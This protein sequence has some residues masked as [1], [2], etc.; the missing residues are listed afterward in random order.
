MKGI[1][2][3][4]TL[5]FLFLLA[6]CRLY[7]Q[8]LPIVQEKDK[9]Q[10][11][12]AV[13]AMYDQGQFV[14]ALQVYKEMLLQDPDNSNLN[15]LVADCLLNIDGYEKDAAP[16]LQKA[17]L[18]T[19]PDYVN[20]MAQRKAPVFAYLKLGDLQYNDYQFDEALINY[21]IF[22]VYLDEKRDKALLEEVNKKI[23]T[24]VN[25]RMMVE[26][27]VKVSFSEIPFVNT[28]TFSDYGAQY[29]DKG[30]TL[31]FSRKRTGT[32]APANSDIFYMRK[33]EGKWG[34]PVRMPFVNSDGDDNFCC[35]SKDGNTMYFAS[36]RDGKF[37]IYSATR[38]GKTQWSIPE[39]L[40][41]NINTAKSEETFAWISADMKTLYF[42]SDRKGGYGG[43]DL[44]RSTRTLGGDWGPAENL[45]SVVNTSGNEESP[46]LSE[47]GKH[48][49]FSS[50]GH[51]GMGG[52]DVFTAQVSGNALK[53]IRNA[54]F[55]INTLGDDLYYSRSPYRDA[56]FLVSR[57]KAGKN[58]FAITPLAEATVAMDVTE[59]KKKEQSKEKPK[60]K[61]VPKTLKY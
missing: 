20:T 8:F 28:V 6:G 12:I 39:L 47:D 44:Y 50:T 16:Y 38:K 23:E 48:F 57:S 19:V 35:V 32:T 29:A 40:N 37:H 9:Q 42:S 17:I 21:K 22:K 54:G 5:A 14:E 52:Y 41:A 13:K 11:F 30:N 26:N 49:Y 55:P 46:T 56:E 36:N 34:R 7:A 58:N 18:N 59:V 27:V 24:A 3:R 45:G 53:D 33:V 31:Y 10:S 51:P 15:F 1:N 2:I 61:L 4:L 25:A 60:L 43:R